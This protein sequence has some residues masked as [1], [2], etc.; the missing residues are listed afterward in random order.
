MPYVSS[1]VWCRA[2]QRLPGAGAAGDP[3]RKWLQLIKF[4]QGLIARTVTICQP[5]G[6]APLYSYMQYVRD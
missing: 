1:S 4:N 6:Y 3:R 5:V 2:T